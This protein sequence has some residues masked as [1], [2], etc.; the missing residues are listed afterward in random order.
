MQE[1]TMEKIK[2]GFSA[3]EGKVSSLWGQVKEKTEETQQSVP[4]EKGAPTVQRV[5]RQQPTVSK[6]RMP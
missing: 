3:I 2:E 6:E 1:Q 4:K 5:V